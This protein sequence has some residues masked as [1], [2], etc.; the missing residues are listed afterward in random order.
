M[1][2]VQRWFCLALLLAIMI[3]VPVCMVQ[4]EI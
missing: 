1:T 2:S 4:G 3:F